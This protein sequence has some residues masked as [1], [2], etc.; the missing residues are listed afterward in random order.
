MFRK[1]AVA[2]CL[3]L[4][5]FT[6]GSAEAALINCPPIVAGDVT[7]TSA[8]QWSTF[9]PANFGDATV[10]TFVNSEAYFGNDDWTFSN[11]LAV[12]GGAS[13]SWN[14]SS[15]IQPTWD[16]V[17]LIFKSADS[18]LLG[19]L[20]TDGSES[21]TWTSPFTDPPFDLPGNSIVQDVSFIRVFFTIDG[22]PGPNGKVP[23][24]ATLGLLGLG[25][26]GL[27]ALRRRER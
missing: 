9:Q 20:V 25:L 5:A 7:N 10:T 8:C 11:S 13:G 1:L 19:Y 3:S 16:D 14:I 26:L 27:V 21:G 4:G 22:A 23:E 12:G 15:V 17:M 2:S 6:F 24:P 18:P